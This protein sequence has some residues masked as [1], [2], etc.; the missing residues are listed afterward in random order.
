MSGGW[1]QI[2]A[3]ITLAPQAKRSGEREGARRKAAGRVRGTGAE[4]LPTYNGLAW[5][6]IV[7]AK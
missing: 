7:L 3:S 6:H 5:S 1:P 4:D 2:L